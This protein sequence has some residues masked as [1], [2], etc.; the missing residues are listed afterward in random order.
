VL[1]P[2]L[3]KQITNI[4]GKVLEKSENGE[5]VQKRLVNESI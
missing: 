3:G 1:L 4:P 5:G 2:G